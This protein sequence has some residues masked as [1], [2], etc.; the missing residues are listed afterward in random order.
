MDETEGVIS[1]VADEAFIGEDDDDYEDLYKDVNVGEGFLQSLWKNEEVEKKLELPSSVSPPN[2]EE[3]SVSILGMSEGRS[4]ASVGAGRK[5]KEGGVKDSD[6]G[7]SR[8]S[9][10]VKRFQSVGFR[11]NEVAVKKSSEASLPPS[12]TVMRVELGHGLGKVAEQPTGPGVGTLGNEGFSRQ[13]IG[14]VNVPG[15]N[16]FR[17]GN[18][19]SPGSGPATGI[20]VG[21]GTW[22]GGGGGGGTILFVKF[23]DEKASGK[24]KGYCQVEFYDHIAATTCKEGM[25]RHLFNGRPYIVAF[26]SPYSVKRMGEAKVNQNQQMAQAAIAQAKMGN[27]DAAEKTRG[28]N[29]ATGGNYQGAI[30]NN[31]GVMGNGANGFGQGIGAAPPF[32]HRQTMM[33]SYGGFLGALAPPFSGSQSP[34]PPVGGFGLPGVASHVNPTFFGRG[35]PM[36]SMGMMTSIG[37]EGHNMGMWSDPNMIRWASKE[38][39]GR[40]GES[41]YKE[42]AASD[43]P[44][45]KEKDKGL[46]RDWFGSSKKRYQDDREPIHDRD[47]PWE[48][49]TGHDHEWSKR[50]HCDDRDVGHNKER[51]ED[52]DRER[53]ER[54]VDRHRY[55]DR[56]SE[57][58]EWE[59]GQSS[60][61]HRKSQLSQEEEQCPRSRG[62]EYGKRQ[63]L[64]SE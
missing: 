41:S 60:R 31:R 6:V 23:F 37:I 20:G 59:R 52:C 64:T 36:G 11:G 42:E 46:E 50:R 1:A 45:G 55:R 33:G 58:D 16:M 49:D 2:M 15:D 14:N 54:Y 32:L 12:S 7:V 19:P 61:T 56:E 40:A 9:R 17:N 51:F 63:C 4:G 39:A 30:D 25:N 18:G 62:A 35:M 43:H 3:S 29:I 22:S 38:Q 44:Y 5:F 26:A 24:S 8:V 48:K 34:F 53:D 27:G 21:A 13:G 57:Y 28:S 47:M 10:R